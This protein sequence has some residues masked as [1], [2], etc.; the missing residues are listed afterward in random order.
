VALK[1]P[2]KSNSRYPF[3]YKISLSETFYQIPSC[4]EHQNS[5]FL[6]LYFREFTAA[7]NFPRSKSRL[8]IG[9]NDVILIKYHTVEITITIDTTIL[10]KKNKKLC[11]YIRAVF[12]I[13][14]DYNFNPWSIFESMMSFTSIL[15]QGKLMAAVNSLK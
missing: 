8:R 15:N 1:M 13:N 2:L 11:S 4:Y 14:C 5:R 9:V 3:S 7:I 6:D 12:Y 10:I